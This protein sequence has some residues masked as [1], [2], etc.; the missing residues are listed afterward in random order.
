M[1]SNN[2]ITNSKSN[3]FAR[4]RGNH[5]GESQS[6]TTIDEALTW[7]QHTSRELVDSG[8]ANV[9]F[10]IQGEYN[11]NNN[12]EHATSSQASNQIQVQAKH[13]LYD[14]TN[15]KAKTMKEKSN[16]LPTDFFMVSE[17]DVKT[18]AAATMEA[19]I[20]CKKLSD[21]EFEEAIM[22]VSNG[23]V[24]L[25]RSENNHDRIDFNF[26]EPYKKTH[27]SKDPC[28]KPLEAI[29]KTIIDTYMLGRSRY[30]ATMESDASKSE[31]SINNVLTSGC[32]NNTT[33]DELIENIIRTIHTHM[34]DD[35][36]VKA[37]LSCHSA[38]VD[39]EISAMTGG[40]ISCSVSDTKVTLS[41]GSGVT[42]SLSIEDKTLNDI[43]HEIRAIL[44]RYLLHA[45]ISPRTRN[46]IACVINLESLADKALMEDLI[47]NID[48]PLY[49]YSLL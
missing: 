7:V 42:C 24:S 1:K 23:L 29:E 30:S 32:H 28:K 14:T 25:R 19:A 33:V 3:I 41:C 9:T 5:Y 47:A 27:P 31:I 15:K 34:L 8:Y 22:D 20:K 21:N 43:H 11:S 38:G 36:N 2:K 10:T 26:W 35:V 12:R 39:A 46:A 13:N 18:I 17:R 40:T 45:S 37:Y 16:I 44:I 49:A 4:I 48:T 6:F